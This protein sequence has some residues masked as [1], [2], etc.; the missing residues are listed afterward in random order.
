MTSQANLA[1]LP[2]PDVPSLAT[3]DEADRLHAELATVARRLSR[4]RSDAERLALVGVEQGCNVALVAIGDAL[5]LVPDIHEPA[6]NERDWTSVGP[7]RVSAARRVATWHGTRL[8]LT[9][10]ELDLLARLA[11]DPWR[12][13]A[14]AELLREVWGFAQSFPKTRA[15]DTHASR[16]RRKL[17][18]AG[19]PAGGWIINVWGVGYALRPPL[20]PIDNA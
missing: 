19:A 14:K 4:A 5:E 3:P 8:D 17:Q 12:V 10:R 1:Y 7:L 2:L 15:V 11:E 16:L 20:A 9:G 18:T 6:R 13:V